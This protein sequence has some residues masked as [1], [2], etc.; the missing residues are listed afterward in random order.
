M[1]ISALHTFK[2]ATATK[3]IGPEVYACRCESLRLDG[4]SLAYSYWLKWAII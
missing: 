3:K 2:L 1:T 4:Y